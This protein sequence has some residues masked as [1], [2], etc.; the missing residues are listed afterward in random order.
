MRVI[1]LEFRTNYLAGANW[2]YLT[3][4]DG[5][6]HTFPPRHGYALLRL[7]FLVADFVRM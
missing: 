3:K 6:Y 7:I 4:Q 5:E 1:S 2:A